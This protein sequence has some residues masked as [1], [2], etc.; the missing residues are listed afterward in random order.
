MWIRRAEARRILKRLKAAEHRIRD[1]ENDLKEERERNRAHE[2]ELVNAV[3]TAAGRY[4]IPKDLSDK[5]TKMA[6]PASTNN[7]LTAMQEAIRD[8]YRQDCA[9]NGR[10]EQ[11]ADAM[12]EKRLRG[13]L[14][15][16]DEPFTFQ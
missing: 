10:T 8:A 11:E 7:Q 16:E 13:E 5:P 1:L 6:T 12:F 9:L 4:A 3:L 14:P 2:K 15:I